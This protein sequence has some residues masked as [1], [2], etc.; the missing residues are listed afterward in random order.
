MESN[1][2]EGQHR[3]MLRSR[4]AKNGMRSDG[5]GTLES[6][7]HV[8]RPR[9][10]S[11]RPAETS[12]DLKPIHNPTSANN[13]SRQHSFEL[14]LVRQQLLAHSIRCHTD[15]PRS[16]TTTPAPRFPTYPILAST[17]HGPTPARCLRTL[18]SSLLRTPPISRAF[19]TTPSVSSN[20]GSAPLTI[21]AG[22]TFDVLPPPLPKSGKQRVGQQEASP[23]VQIRG[24]LGQ[25]QMPIPNFVKIDFDPVARKASVKV[26]D[27]K[28]R[29]Q[30]EMWGMFHAVNA[31]CGEDVNE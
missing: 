11:I 2:V 30:R 14:N 23:S 16:A 28:E 31:C 27:A 19:T 5:R 1:A 15:L 9:A 24:P 8:R 21:P 25:L 18:P 4:T 29:R 26:V 6:R 12:I 22:V 7:N 20:I 17:M 3:C 10:T 13:L